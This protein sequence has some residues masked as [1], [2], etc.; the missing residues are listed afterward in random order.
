MFCPGC[1]NPN[2]RENTFCR[3]CGN[4][5]PDLSGK[6]AKYGKKTE[7][8]QELIRTNL[9]LNLMSAVVSIVSA[10]ALYILF[11]NRG[12]EFAA[13]FAIAAF[14]LAMG[15]WQLSTFFNGLKLRKKFNLNTNQAAQT[16]QAYTPNEVERI[17]TNELLTEANFSSTLPQSVTENTTRQLSEIPRK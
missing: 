10:I 13:V 7:T 15:G 6:L 16:A 5:L 8:S 12:S 11:W 2:Q 14:L 17:K 1:G 3:Q 4:F 9:I